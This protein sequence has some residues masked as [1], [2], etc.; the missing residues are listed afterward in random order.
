MANYISESNACLGVL[1]NFSKLLID[2]S[3]PICNERLVRVVYDSDQTQLVSFN[4]N[5]YDLESRISKFYSK[6]H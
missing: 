3:V 1:T 2:P 5:E 4:S 6:Y